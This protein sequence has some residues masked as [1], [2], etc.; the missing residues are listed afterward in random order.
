VGCTADPTGA[1]TST[2]ADTTADSP[3]A[4]ATEIAGHYTG[5]STAY[6]VDENGN[7]VQAYTFHEDITATNPEMKDGRA[8]VHVSDT[9]TG[10]PHPQ[11]WTEGFFVNADGSTGARFFLMDNP[12][13]TEVI[14]VP[15]ANGGATFQTDFYPGEENALGFGGK[16]IFYKKHTTVKNTVTSGT[17]ETDLISR[18]TT[19]SWKDASGAPQ[20]KSFVSM[21]GYQSRT[22]APK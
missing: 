7:V 16:D 8:V 14:E 1:G 13:S 4:R 22:I 5:E 2:S 11:T 15:I 9:I 17:T 12:G 19:I 6:R 3:L 18:V 21:N 20:T 10:L